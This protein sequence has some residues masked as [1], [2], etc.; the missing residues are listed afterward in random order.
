MVGLGMEC[1]PVRKASGK[2]YVYTMLKSDWVRLVF[3]VVLLRDGTRAFREVALQRVE[4]SLGFGES[5]YVYLWDW[6]LQ[7]PF[8]VWTCWGWV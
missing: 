1:K 3:D 2:A 7:V 8:E 5:F 6:E 4:V